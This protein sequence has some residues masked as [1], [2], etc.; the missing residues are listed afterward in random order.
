MDS[1][2]NVCTGILMRFCAYCVCVYVCVC[3]CV[4]VCL[5]CVYLFILCAGMSYSRVGVGGVLVPA[6]H[7]TALVLRLGSGMFWRRG[8]CAQRA[9][10]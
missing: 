7:V 1:C 4:C 10:R 2:V 3:V 9:I 8:S 5:L 6:R